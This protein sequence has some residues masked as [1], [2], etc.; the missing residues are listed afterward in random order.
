MEPISEKP[1]TEDQFQPLPAQT[2]G[3]I[4]N[5]TINT[6]N[7]IKIGLYIFLWIIIFLS[8]ALGYAAYTYK[9]I[10]KEISNN[11]TLST[12]SK[13]IFGQQPISQTRESTNT[14]NTSDSEKWTEMIVA[15]AESWTE[16]TLPDS[17]TWTEAN[18]IQ[19]E[20][21]T[22]ASS[23]PENQETLTASRNQDYPGMASQ[24]VIVPDI[25]TDGSCNN[26]CWPT[27]YWNGTA[28]LESWKYKTHATQ[29]VTNTA[30]NLPTG[31]FVTHFLWDSGNC[32]GDDY[33]ISG[34]SNMEWIH[35][36]NKCQS[37]EMIC[38][39]QYSDSCIL[40]AGICTCYDP[41]IPSIEQ[42]STTESVVFAAGGSQGIET[43]Y[44]IDDGG[45][46]A[47]IYT[48][49]VNYTEKPVVLVL[50][51]YNPGIWNIS[52]SEGTK[53]SK[54]ILGW[55]YGQ[56]VAS[57]SKNIP[58]EEHIYQYKKTNDYFY[59]SQ[60]ETTKSSL[61]KWG[62]IQSISYENN[63]EILIGN[64]PSQNIKWII[65]DPENTPEK[66]YNKWD[67]LAGEAGLELL[68]QKG[69]LRVAT[70]EDAKKWFEELTKNPSSYFSKKEWYPITDPDDLALLRNKYTP[71]WWSN[72]YVALKDFTLPGGMYWKFSFYVPKWITIRW[73]ISNGSIYDYNTMECRWSCIGTR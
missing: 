17:E 33:N 12:L 45:Y 68:V 24:E 28:C 40:S 62:N 61:K 8:V 64:P 67:N 60:W 41:K 63:G 52:V 18:F 32:A 72:Y 1:Q 14:I 21:M 19:G 42:L 57:I 11:E 35:A 43:K 39:K 65:Q 55:Y 73:D 6:P 56:K 66:Y 44:Q 59:I 25:C 22:E 5:N 38:K 23:T 54:I 51:S 47:K 29:C 20:D 53:I 16:W 15:N 46:F 26:G 4:G 70:Q 9:G 34:H 36:N 3:I 48:V 10:P 37:W 50:G 27:E 69:I 58:I 31:Y 30:T 7:T 2:D 71:Q 49:K 13:S